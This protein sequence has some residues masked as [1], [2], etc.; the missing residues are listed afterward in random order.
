VNIIG[1]WLN[2]RQTSGE[3]GWIFSRG[4]WG[5]LIEKREER[6][7]RLDFWAPIEVLRNLLCN[8]L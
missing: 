2:V 5:G 1:R 4:F 3:K 8:V 7:S 6:G